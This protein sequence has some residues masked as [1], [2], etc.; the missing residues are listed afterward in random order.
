[1]RPCPCEGGNKVKV[2]K[3]SGAKT[4]NRAN[5]TNGKPHS[6]G[7]DKQVGPISG[8]SDVVNISLEAIAAAKIEAAQEVQQVEETSVE[9]ALPDPHETSRAMLEKELA[10]VFRATYL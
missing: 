9:G 4:V 1:M 10:R 8:G 7:S 2:S 5:A 6:V 3:S